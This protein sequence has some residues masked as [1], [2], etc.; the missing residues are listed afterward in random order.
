MNVKT[1]RLF[2]VAPWALLMVATGVGFLYLAAVLCIAMWD[3]IKGFEP[4]CAETACKPSWSG[5][6]RCSTDTR[7]EVLGDG[8]V[9]CRC[10][11]DAGAP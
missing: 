9:L 10:P 1:K 11:I 8:T 6:C 4:R 3:N 7:I 2:V 5:D